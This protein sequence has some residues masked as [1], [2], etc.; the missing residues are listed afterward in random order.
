MN[1]IN[2]DSYRIHMIT[3][4]ERFLA[5]L[6]LHDAELNDLIEYYTKLHNLIECLGYEFSLQ[7]KE[8]RSR[9]K[10]LEGFLSARND[11]K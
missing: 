8:I 1:N 3:L 6:S 7:K 5:A 9:L 10:T 2:P 11:D 4:N